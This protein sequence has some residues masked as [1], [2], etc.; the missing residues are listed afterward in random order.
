MKPVLKIARKPSNL[1]AEDTYAY[2]NRAG[3][4]FRL[5][6]SKAKQGDIAK[7]QRYYQGA[8]RDLD[9]ELSNSNPELAD[10]YN[11]R[12]IAR[13]SLGESKDSQGDIAG[14][15]KFIYGSD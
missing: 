13:A 10:L 4:K 15:R 12:G 14:A 9:R 11:N 6:Q 2:H 1:T 5:G 3:G 8:I 7:G